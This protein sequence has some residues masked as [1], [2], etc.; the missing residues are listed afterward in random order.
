MRIKNIKVGDL[1]VVDS[2]KK[3]ALLLK[4]TKKYWYY[5]MAGGERRIS[6]RRAWRNIDTGLIKIQEAKG[7]RK[8]Q[9]KD[10]VLDL[11]GTKHADV[12]EKVRVFLNFVDLPCTIITGDSPVMSRLVRQ[13]VEEYK[14]HSRPSVSNYGE[15][16]VSELPL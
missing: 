13:V 6:K 9:R 4:Q 3:Q 10:R 7:M 12:D 11:H 8:K 1:L 14:W 15:I 2:L 5:F 16:V